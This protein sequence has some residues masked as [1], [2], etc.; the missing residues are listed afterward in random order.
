[1]RSRRG[2][3]RSFT[4]KDREQD[5]KQTQ[6]AK[7]GAKSG[8]R[9]PCGP[10]YEPKC[11]PYAL[12]RAFRDLGISGSDQRKPLKLRKNRRRKAPV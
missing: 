12:L 11:G 5:Q 9:T 10:G 7:D 6:P 3:G 1:M 2:G 4:A 8:N